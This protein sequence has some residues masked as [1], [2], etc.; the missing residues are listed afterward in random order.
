VG[1]WREKSTNY[2]STFSNNGLQYYTSLK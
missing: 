1:G 2:C